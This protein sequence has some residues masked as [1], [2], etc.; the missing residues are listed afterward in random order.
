MVTDNGFYYYVSNKKNIQRGIAEKLLTTYNI[1]HGK[2]DDA[3]QPNF[4]S[5]KS[6]IFV[7]DR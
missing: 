6:Y 7:I 3:E 4:V 2:Y 5:L 1:N